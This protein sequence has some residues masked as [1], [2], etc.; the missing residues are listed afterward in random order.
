LFQCEVVV[1]VLCSCSFLP[2]SSNHLVTDDK[3]T[4]L[5]HLEVSPRVVVA[6]CMSTLCCV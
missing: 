6:G 2:R 3:E 1:A 5:L 4:P